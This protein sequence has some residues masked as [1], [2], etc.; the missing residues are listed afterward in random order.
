MVRK[1]E[2][3]LLMA[4]GGFVSSCDLFVM[5]LHSHMSHL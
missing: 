1:W 2:G 3:V 5:H 4:A